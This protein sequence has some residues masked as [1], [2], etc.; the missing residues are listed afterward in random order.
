[1]HS[2]IEK[3]LKKVDIIV[4]SENIRICENCRRNP[5][6]YEVKY[7]DHIL[8]KYYNIPM[9]YQSIRPAVRTMSMTFSISSILYIL[10][11]ENIHYSQDCQEVNKEVSLHQNHQ[12]V[13]IVHRVMLITNT[14]H[15]T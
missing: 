9:L 10:C 15:T 13:I 14:N 1:M 3:H 8:F 7:L 12:T 4:P 5:K 6:Q 11:N 2:F